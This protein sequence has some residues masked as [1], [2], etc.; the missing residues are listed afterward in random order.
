MR[1]WQSDGVW[2]CDGV[3]CAGWQSDG[4]WVCDGVICEGMAQ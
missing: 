3:I 4:V 1:G 2:V